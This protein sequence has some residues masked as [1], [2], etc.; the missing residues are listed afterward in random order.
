MH[1]PQM[2]WIPADEPSL[3]DI[4]EV[5]SKGDVE[6]VLTDTTRG[7]MDSAAGLIFGALAKS[8]WAAK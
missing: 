3:D 7:G 4:E 8:R 2:R 6:T 5:L 1:F